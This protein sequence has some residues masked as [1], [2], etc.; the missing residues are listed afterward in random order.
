[1][2]L[3]DFSATLFALKGRLG[4]GKIAHF[5]G[6]CQYFLIII[7]LQM[8]N[9][10]PHRSL[11]SWYNLIKMKL[12]FSF[13][14]IKCGKAMEL[15][16]N[17]GYYICCYLFI[18]GNI[19]AQAIEII[20]I[21]CI[22]ISPSSTFFHLSIKK[23]DHATSSVGYIADEVQSTPHF[24]LT[25]YFLTPTLIYTG[26]SFTPKSMEELCSQVAHKEFLYTIYIH[27]SNSYIRFSQKLILIYSEEN[28]LQPSFHTQGCL[29]ST[30]NMDI[31]GTYVCLLAFSLQ[32]GVQIE[33]WK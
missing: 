33:L 2:K 26:V 13:I 30:A 8:T 12:I 31:F 22:K 10:N 21:Q 24:S 16:C 6:L 28:V 27:K 9:M 14:Q 1:M 29:R 17:R 20:L 5:L 15:F 32:T 3:T 19:P 4:V 11:D 7:F 25:L 23:G 18:S